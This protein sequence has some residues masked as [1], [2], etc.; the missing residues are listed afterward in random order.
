[1]GHETP[2]LQEGTPPATRR[3]F[4]TVVAALATGA[5]A[6]LTPLAAG[7]ASFFSPLRRKAAPST[8]R[9]ALLD[10]VPDDGVPR[11]FPVLADRED[12]WNRYPAQRIGAVYLVRQPGE[13]APVAFTAKCPHAGCFIGYTAGED[14]FKCPCHTS[15]FKLDG[16]RVRGDAEVSPRDMDQ[17]TVELRTST[18]EDAADAASAEEPGGP[19]RRRRRRQRGAPD[20]AANAATDVEVVEVWVEFVDFQTGHKER[21]ATV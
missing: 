1:M 16:T 11:A 19:Q 10:Q 8:V 20:A 15:A 9:V 17:L 3:S 18:G 7:L 5:I 21:V 14:T 4:A 13:K 6:T 12:A 2:K